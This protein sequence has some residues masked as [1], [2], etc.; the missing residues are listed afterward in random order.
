MTAEKRF[1][2]DELPR[3]WG[4]TSDGVLAAV[5]AKKKNDI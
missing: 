1:N 4:K 5:K 2:N 3:Y